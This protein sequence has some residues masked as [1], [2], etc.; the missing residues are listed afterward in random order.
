MA[1]DFEP[2]LDALSRRALGGACSGLRR[3][4]AGASQ[5][6][7]SFDVQGMGYILRRA[8]GGTPI[9]ASAQSI[10]LEKEAEVIRAVVAANAPA[11]VVAH[12]CT[13]DEGLG[14]AYIMQRLSGETIARKILRD[15]PYTDAHTKLAGQ[16]GAALARIHATP[17]AAALGLPHADA[18]SQLAQYEAIYRSF[19]IDRPVFELAFAM[20]KRRAPAPCAPVLCHGDFRLGNLMIDET[21]LVA[22]LD[23]ELAHLGDPAEDLGWLC[24]PSWRFGQI[25]KPVGGFGGISALLSAYRD[26]GGARDV[27]E[28]RVRFWTQFGALK[29]G[30]MCLIMFRAYDS[31]FDK[32]VERAAIGRRASETELDLVLMMKGLL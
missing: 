16:C 6:T 8:P 5:E 1:I 22:A 24:T 19:A 17:D 25:E 14:V 2:S 11:P 10:G 28:A 31:G 32:S 9:A 12:V 21:G 23:W 20:L 18:R 30:I 3:L 29:W 7:W 27:D 13:P 26:A 4:S 15:A